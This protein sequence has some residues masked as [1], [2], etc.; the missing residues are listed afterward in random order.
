MAGLCLI[1]GLSIMDFYWMRTV[2]PPSL[3]SREKSVLY[4]QSDVRNLGQSTALF[5]TSTID[6]ISLLNNLGD[7][8]QVKSLRILSLF[9]KNLRV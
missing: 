9:G 1:I 3:C 8:W 6:K 5:V 4:L 7:F 2:T